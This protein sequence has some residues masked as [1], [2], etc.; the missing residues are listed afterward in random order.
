MFGGLTEEE[1]LEIHSYLDE[2]VYPKGTCILRQG[3]PNNSV[4]FIVEG[5]VAIQ[6]YASDKDKAP[7]IITNLHTGDSFG[8]MELIDIQSCA[9]SVICLTDTKVITL[10]N[11]DLYRLS[12]THL[13]TYT[14]LILNLARDISRRLRS[15]DD[16][17]SMV[18]KRNKPKGV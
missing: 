6:K 12:T 15:T 14:M 16:L 10:S 9:A 1:L 17:L 8:E 4:Y 11:K 5:E 3:E 13:K 2:R 7:R 18:S